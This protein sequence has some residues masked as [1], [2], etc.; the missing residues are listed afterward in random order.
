V[1]VLPTNYREKVVDGSAVSNDRLFHNNGDGTFTDVTLAA[2][3]LYEGFG[4]GLAISD[5]NYDGWPDIYV[6]NDYLTNDLLYINNTDGTFSNNIE[7]YIKHQSKFAMGC[8][9][10]DFNNDGYLDIVTLDMLGETNY[11]MKTTVMGNN[12]INYVLNDRWDYQYQYMRNMLQLGNGS[13]LPFSEIGLLSG[14]SRT[15]WSW[16]PL[17]I[18]ADNDGYRD[19]LVTN[20]FP[21]DITDM[22][23]ADY[24][25]NISQYFGAERIL[26]SI[27][28]VKIPNY[29][30]R[31]KGDLTFEDVGENW[32]L[33]IP[34]FSNGAAYVDLDNDGDLDY[35][36]NN[37]NEEAFV[38]ENT[39]EKKEQPN[40]FLKIEFK[41]ET[42]NPLGLGAKI[43]LR[44]A[45]GQ[46]QYHEHRLTRGYMSS[47]EPMVHFGVG[48][49]KVIESVSILWPD[50]A[51]QE[52]KSVETD[53]TISFDYQNAVK[54]DS[55]KVVPNSFQIKESS[56]TFDEVSKSFGVTYVHQEKDIVDYNVQGILPHK[57]TQNGPCLIV[58]DINGDS[59]EDFIVGSSSTF[60][61]SVFFQQTDG[62]FVENPL[63]ETAQDKL[64]EE[65]S[66]V[67][68][69]LENDGDLDLYLVSGSNEFPMESEQY[70]DR[71]FL[72]DGRGNFKIAHDVM[73]KI[74]SSGSVV[75]AVDFDQDGY[76]DLFVGGRTP[77]GKFPIPDRSFLLKNT[78]GVLNDVTESYLPQLQKLGMV[79]EAL[80]LDIDN[81]ALSDLVVI[82]EMMSIKV[83]K[84]HKTS[85]KEMDNTGF[86]NKL[87][88]WESIASADFDNDGDQDLVVGNLGRNNFYQPTQEHPVSLIAKDFDGNGS[89]DPIMFT[90]QKDI[91]GSVKAYPRNFWSE[92]SK[93]S[94]L[95]RS[96]Y[97]FYKEYAK[98]TIETLLT[99]EELKDATVLT[100]NY[101]RSIYAENL[102]N[103]QFKISELPLR[104]QFGP[105]NAFAITDYDHDGKKDVLLIGNDFGNEIF[106]GR[107]DALNGLLMKGQ[108][109]GDFEVQETVKSGFLV[110][111]DAKSMAMIKSASNKDLIL[112]TQNRGELLIFTQH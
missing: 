93:Q 107:Y 14:I 16:S 63:F 98:A 67:L 49:E 2:G 111:G 18:D 80:W 90:Y 34:S 79:T 40:H 84:N 95:F 55:A 102:G 86:E 60:S 11:R 36:V 3:I 106:V 8:D 44:F 13:D 22:D 62:N 43:V 77:V 101:D 76:T 53:A 33:D 69:D 104:A 105:V 108:G 20:G 32:G 5:I 39:S 71:I 1:H 100:A 83:F 68:F 66:M 82:G 92:L 6:T 46:L 7:D 48:S 91:D 56:P 38:F 78:D 54:S 52:K 61:P 45:S 42:N 21:R 37:I 81:D 64:F 88:W 29:A 27:P 65:E 74:N 17:F 109:N 26:D 9:V 51:F 59:L 50:G 73:P 24:R 4:L 12:Y 58:G 15:D 87:G 10:S 31:N 41:G 85:F 47:M 25:L 94:P 112:V 97:N 28:V 57:L 30:Y 89:V 75:K 70:S 35:V 103:G 19:L 72:N 110:P 96:K 23:F 99:Q